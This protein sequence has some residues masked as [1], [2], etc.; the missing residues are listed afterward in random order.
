MEA[1]GANV[2]YAAIVESTKTEAI[3][4]EIVTVINEL[5]PEAAVLERVGS[6]KEF[7]ESIAAATCQ[8]WV[9]FDFD[10]FDG[11]AWSQ[12][13]RARS[14]LERRPVQRSG[15]DSS[16]VVLVLSH[17]SFA[18]LQ[19]NAPNI[20]SWIGGSVFALES[21]RPLSEM[22]RESRLE[23]LRRWGAMTDE[24]NED[25]SAFFADVSRRD[26][27]TRAIDATKG[28]SRR[29]AYDFRP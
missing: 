5:Q 11:A 16:I 3:A 24:E 18:T 12:L 13:D 4:R 19:A 28:G 20:A 1:S 27:G 2:W 8:V 23:E 22:A 9:G 7:S 26:M 14:R 21:E 15:V 6:P 25:R 10:H 29:N 17:E